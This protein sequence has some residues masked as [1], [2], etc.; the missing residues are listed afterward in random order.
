MTTLHKQTSHSPE[1][2][3]AAFVDPLLATKLQYPLFQ[4]VNRYRRPNSTPRN[5][6]YESLSK[7]NFFREPFYRH[8]LDFAAQLT[9]LVWYAKKKQSSRKLGRSQ[10]N[11]FKLPRFIRAQERYALK[12]FRKL[13]KLKMFFKRRSFSKKAMF[14]SYRRVQRKYDRRLDTKLNKIKRLLK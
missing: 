4:F 3:T 11:K 9:Y 1:K 7:F 10:T 5:L 12:K 6:Q 8:A 14:F 13:N 2:S